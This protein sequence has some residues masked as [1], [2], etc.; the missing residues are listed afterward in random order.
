ML[1]ARSMISF[2]R[3]QFKSLARTVVMLQETEVVHTP[4][5]RNCTGYSEPLHWSM[6]RPW[7]GEEET[8]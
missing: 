8:P 4:A 6:T 5:H 2:T 3:F 7:A 1:D